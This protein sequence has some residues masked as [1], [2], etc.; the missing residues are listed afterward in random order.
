[1]SVINVTE[2][3]VNDL[4]TLKGFIDKE[5]FKRKNEEQDKLIENF[6]KAFYDL[7]EAG[8]TIEYNYD[9]N[10]NEL[11]NWDNFYFE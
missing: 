1:M 10:N 4:I 9:D 2:M 6:K 11:V 5:I 3:S 7:V 8:V